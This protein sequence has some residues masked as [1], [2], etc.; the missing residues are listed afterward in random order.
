VNYGVP[1]FAGHSA[2]DFDREELAREIRAVLTAFEPR[3]KSSATKVSV[4]IGDK[5]AGLTIDIDAL[6]IMA[7][8]PERLKLRTM[9]DL[10]NGLARTTLKDA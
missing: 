7:P 4:A 3:L 5:W 1:S 9:I 2:R 6:L 10:D 8:A